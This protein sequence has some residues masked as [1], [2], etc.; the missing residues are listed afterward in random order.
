MYFMILENILPAIAEATKMKYRIYYE[1]WW[2]AQ[3]VYDFLDKWVLLINGFTKEYLK[4][5]W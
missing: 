5:L 1:D 4:D 3:T 2:N